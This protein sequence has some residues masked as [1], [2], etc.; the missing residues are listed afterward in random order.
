V[1]QSQQQETLDRFLSLKNECVYNGYTYIQ[2]MDGGF[3][4]SPEGFD[5]N[6]TI[7][8]IT[9]FPNKTVWKYY[10]FQ[11][12]AHAAFKQFVGPLVDLPFVYDYETVRLILSE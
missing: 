4:I 10:L 12:P 2:S 11:D 5:Q 7:A 3:H 8:V 9:T 1:T 6:M